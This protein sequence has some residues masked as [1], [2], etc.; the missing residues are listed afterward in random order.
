MDFET[1]LTRRSDAA[2]AL[3]EGYYR[4]ERRDRV[5]VPVRIWFGPPAD[6]VTGETLERSHRWQVT[7]GGKTLG[8]P[9]CPELEDFWPRCAGNR[10][11]QAEHDFLIATAGYAREHDAFSPFAD[12]RGRINLLNATIPIPGE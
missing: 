12:A 9:G 11:D 1:A 3:A 7:V 4:W 8:D 2:D 5:P 10:V 6:P